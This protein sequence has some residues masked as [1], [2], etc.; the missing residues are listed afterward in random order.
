MTATELATEIYKHVASLRRG[1]Y[2]WDEWDDK[3]EIQHIRALIEDFQRL[4]NLGTVST[5]P[6]NLHLK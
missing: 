5:E 4:E 6:L 1:G 2:H 3:R